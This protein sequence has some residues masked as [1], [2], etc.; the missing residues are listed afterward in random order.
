MNIENCNKLLKILKNITSTLACE[1]ADD[2]GTLNYSLGEYKAHIDL[3]QMEEQ[4]RQYDDRFR[5]AFVF[6]PA[7]DAPV[8]TATARA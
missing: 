8:T 5:R 4:R 1:V 7:N 2:K 3:A 6:D